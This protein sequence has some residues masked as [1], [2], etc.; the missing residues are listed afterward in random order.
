[1]RPYSPIVYFKD[2]TGRPEVRHV[3]RDLWSSKVWYR[4]TLQPPY[5]Q[6]TKPAVRFATT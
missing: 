4:A 3:L 6:G 5:P 2:H 1:M